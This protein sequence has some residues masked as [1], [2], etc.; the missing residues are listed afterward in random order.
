MARHLITVEIGLAAL[1]FSIFVFTYVR[2]NWRNTREGRHVM[3]TTVILAGLMIFWFLHRSPVGPFSE[4]V[5][6]GA[7]AA[8]PVA[9]WWRVALLW[10]AQHESPTP[11]AQ[12][13]SRSE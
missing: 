1:G 7:L 2:V 8:L 5:W 10:R 4:W 9:A 3:F 11:E 12:S 6:A 13:A